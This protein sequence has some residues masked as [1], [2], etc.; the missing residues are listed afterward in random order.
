MSE[1]DDWD[2]LWSDLVDLFV[3][4]PRLWW[5][6]AVSGALLIGVAIYLYGY[7]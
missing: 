2:Y 7:R 1:D 6:F 4:K 5:I 3:E